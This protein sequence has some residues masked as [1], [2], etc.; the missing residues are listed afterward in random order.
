M[1]TAVHGGWGS[2]FKLVKA[3]LK[4]E[5]ATP[6]ARDAENNRAQMLPAPGKQRKTLTLPKLAAHRPPALHTLLSAFAAH[7]PPAL[8]TLLSALGRTKHI[9]Y[10]RVYSQY[11]A[12]GGASVRLGEL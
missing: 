11:D 3:G 9:R 7:R 12:Y 10:L 2:Q 5:K 4:Q 1:H 8:H 6:G